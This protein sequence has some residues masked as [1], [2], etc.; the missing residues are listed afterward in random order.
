[1][2]ARDG[3]VVSIPFPVVRQMSSLEGL[4]QLHQVQIG[5][6]RQR[7]QRHLQCVQGDSG[8]AV[9][10]GGQELEELVLDLHVAVW[11]LLLI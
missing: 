2:H 10:R 9:G 4:F 11:V 6:G 8:I 5:I 7:R 1:M 3:I